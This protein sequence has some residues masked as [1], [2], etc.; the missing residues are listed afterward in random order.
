M[1]RLPPKRDPPLGRPSPRSRPASS[2]SKDANLARKAAKPRASSG[3]K[4]R[5]VP[6]GSKARKVEGTS[7]DSRSTFAAV[8]ASVSCSEDKVCLG[9]RKNGLKISSTSAFA[10]MQAPYSVSTCVS[11]SDFARHSSASQSLNVT[12]GAKAQ[13]RT[14]PWPTTRAM[15]VCHSRSGAA[16]SGGNRRSL[17]K[18]SRPLTSM[19]E[20]TWRPRRFKAAPTMASAPAFSAEPSGC[21]ANSK[22]DRK[23]ERKAD[24]ARASSGECR[25]ARW[26]SKCSE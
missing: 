25:A 16:T 9:R 22:M 19:V 26:R 10:T 1:W 8:R 3:A 18:C 4:I 23:P 5:S 2:P 17:N 6:C 21:E 13:P 20:P 24:K 12:E 15:A 14:A 11:N 7:A